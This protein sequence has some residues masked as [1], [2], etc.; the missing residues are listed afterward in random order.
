MRRTLIGFAITLAAVGVSAGT[1][2]ASS[3]TT[4]YNSIP[5]P[6]PGNIPSVSFE[7]TGT[8]EFGDQV[9]FARRARTLK[10]VT[11][12]MSSWGCQRGHWNT[13]DCFTNPGATFR[14]AITLN[15]YAVNGDQ[16]PGALIAKVTPTFTMPYRPSASTK[17]T[18]AFAGEW[19]DKKSETCFNGKAFTITFNLTTV[20]PNNVIF[21]IAYNTTDYGYTPIGP[22]TCPSGGCPYDSLNVGAMGTV[23]PLVGTNPFPNDAYQDT[24]YDSCSNGAITPFGLDAGCW[25]GFKPAVRFRTR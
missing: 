13:G 11:V 19:F 3:L 9:T 20:V 6:L 14:H 24:L 21:G 15:L 16:S 23:P 2:S 17:C 25:G 1:A 8:S 18:G 7:A 5:R 22:A 12:T 4:I 10:K